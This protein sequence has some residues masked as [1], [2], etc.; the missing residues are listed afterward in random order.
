MQALARDLNDE[1]AI[2]HGLDVLA[3]R[4]GEPAKSPGDFLGVHP[5]RIYRA[6]PSAVWTN[7]VEQRDGHYC[8]VRVQIP[9]AR[10]IATSRL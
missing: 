10:I 7:V 2:T 9:V 6:E 3:K 1:V 8:D 5:R 4:K